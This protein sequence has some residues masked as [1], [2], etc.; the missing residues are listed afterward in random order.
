MGTPHIQWTALKT[1]PGNAEAID[2]QTVDVAAPSAA[3]RI[4]VK[5]SN[6]AKI[7]AR[8]I[9]SSGA[10]NFDVDIYLQYGNGEP[11]F[12]ANTVALTVNAATPG[13]FRLETYGAV[14]AFARCYNFAAGGTAQVRISGGD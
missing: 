4:G 1:D 6:R 10:G 9:E 13:L 8:C 11:W 7:T 2:G 5:I 3:D 14:R 12:K